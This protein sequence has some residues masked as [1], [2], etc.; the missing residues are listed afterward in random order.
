MSAVARDIL[1]HYSS[2]KNAPAM[3]RMVSSARDEG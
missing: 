2:I 1:A 3:M